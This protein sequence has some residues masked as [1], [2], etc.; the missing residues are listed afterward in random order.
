MKIKYFIQLALLVFLFGA[1]QKEESTLVN[2]NPNNII[3]N[4]PLAK[5]LSRTSQNPT[6]IDNVIDSTS[7]FRVQL[8]VNI[9]VNT[10]NITV[11]T[12]DDYQLV[13]NVIDA[14][15]ND[16]DIVHF[17]FPM[18]IQY[19]N[20]TTQVISNANQLH[21]A[22][23]SCGEDEGFDEIDCIAINYPIS[24]NIYDSNN[25]VANTISIQSNSQLF[26][27][28]ATLSSGII[29]AIVYPI[30]VTNSNGQNFVI[31]SNVALETFID[32]SINDC[33]DSGSNPTFTPIITS[34]S[35]NVSYFYKDQDETSDYT[36]YHF[37]FISNGTINVIKNTNNSNGSWS[38]Y[39]DSGQNKID[40]SFDNSNLHE[41]DEDWVIIE[42]SATTI[43]LKHE[44]GGGGGSRYLYFSKN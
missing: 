14:N 32:N 8:P 24:I 5:L 36:G 12:Q 26:N 35:W 20:F 27:F 6:S 16:D 29:A 44:S 9:S 37:N 34:G 33:E 23:E 17:Y 19:Q 30:S 13:Q 42:Y 22:I 2:Q 41:L 7:C 38:T 4:S 43:H 21:D 40:L 11:S 3:A 28:I 25:Q 39:T 15:S 1:C 10:Q 31:N 18:T